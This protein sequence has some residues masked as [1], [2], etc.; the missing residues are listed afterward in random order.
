[1][2]TAAVA[3]IQLSKEEQDQLVNDHLKL[4]RAIAIN[5]A[6]T[7][8]I[9]VDKE[10]L[11]Q[12]G[13]VGLIDAASK[14]NPVKNV[15]FGTYAKHRICGAIVDHI[16]SLDWASRDSRRKLSA[17][18][19]GVNELRNRLEREPS[20]EEV[21]H[22]LQLNHQQ[23]VELQQFQILSNSEMVAGEE[24][25]V[26]QIHDRECKL[27]DEICIAAETAK[28]LRV[29]ASFLPDRYC[30]V[31][32]MYYW[33]ELTMHEIGEKLHINESRVS[34]I[35]KSALLKI[36]DRLAEKGLTSNAF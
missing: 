31:I 22:W 24:H 13:R 14:Y 30:K 6:N 11:I 33:D 21:M 34:Q 5:I 20:Q 16:R 29:A 23:I 7:L 1:M 8:P 18:E 15:Y 27:P 3:F 17:Y 9:H 28:L 36:R 25:I 4:V 32:K 19:K 12:A 2:A 35:H 10:D 26:P